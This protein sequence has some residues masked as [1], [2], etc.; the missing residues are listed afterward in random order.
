MYEWILDK[1]VNREVTAEQVQSL[2]PMFF[3]QEQADAILATPQIPIES[4]QE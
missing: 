2:V 1:W 3:T 4:T